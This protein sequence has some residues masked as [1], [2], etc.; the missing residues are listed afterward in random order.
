MSIVEERPLE[1]VRTPDPDPEPGTRHPRHGHGQGSVVGDDTSALA[2]AA[3]IRITKG[4]PTAEEV[5]TLAVLLGA[6]I[7]LQHEA[8][9]AQPAPRVSRLP[10][11]AQPSFVPP[12]SWAS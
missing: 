4:N 6:R 2:L 11:R 12:G 8:R 1:S 7:R 9:A 5:A 10:R 3:A